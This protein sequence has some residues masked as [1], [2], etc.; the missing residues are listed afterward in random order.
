MAKLNALVALSNGL[1][2]RTQKAITALHRRMGNEGAMS[3]LMRTYRAR[4]EE[5]DPLPPESKRVQDSASDIL[6]DALSEW[7]SLWE[8]VIAQDVAN[9]RAM[10][11]LE[12][13]GVVLAKDVPV[14][15]MLWLTKQLDDMHTF[16]KGIPVVDQASE[17]HYSEQAN[18]YATE[19]VE[20]VR[21]KKTPQN[22]IKAPATKEHPAQ[23]EVYPEDVIVG[24]WSKVEY[25][26]AMLASDKADLL[27]R[28]EAVQDAVRV[29]KENANDLDVKR[30]ERLKALF[31]YIAG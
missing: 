18:C 8:L 30:V 1:K 16:A 5:G 24:Y 2:A 14:T 9:T 22:H 4:D 19:P 31:S 26:G 3:G 10:A 12:V 7:K 15:T 29:G 20:T 27:S 13:D 17:W 28:I 11:E 21:T 25:S 23:V 6:E